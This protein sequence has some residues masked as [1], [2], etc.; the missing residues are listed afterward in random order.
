MQLQGTSLQPHLERDA[1]VRDA[2]GRACAPLCGESSVIL[3]TRPLPAAVD[4]PAEGRGGCSCLTVLPSG[5]A[6]PSCGGRGGQA[7]SEAFSTTTCPSTP[8]LA[9]SR[10]RDYP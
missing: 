2:V 5:W 1:P 7:N 3:L 4:A 9:H 6:V 8:A 10:S